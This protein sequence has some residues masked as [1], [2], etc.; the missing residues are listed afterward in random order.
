MEK[1]ILEQCVINPKGTVCEAYNLVRGVSLPY[2][3]ARLDNKIIYR[4]HIMKDGED[5]R[6]KTTIA[7]HDGTLVIDQFI[8]KF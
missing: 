4:A 2:Y 7:F 6:D 8:D 1:V 3:G 5:I